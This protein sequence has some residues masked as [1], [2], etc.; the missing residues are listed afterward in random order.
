[1]ACTNGLASV[2]SAYQTVLPLSRVGSGVAVSPVAADV[3]V[4]EPP[5]D[6]VSDAAA[7]EAAGE[8][9]P[10]EPAAEEATDDAADDVAAGEDADGVPADVAALVPPLS[11]LDE[12]AVASS[13]LT[14]ATTP[15]SS[16]LRFIFFDGPFIGGAASERGRRERGSAGGR[17]P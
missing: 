7:E 17:P 8:L 11:V 12:Q 3:P 9:P 16:L 5:A 14:V 2:T 1:M 15:R 10:E 4:A 6:A 13:A